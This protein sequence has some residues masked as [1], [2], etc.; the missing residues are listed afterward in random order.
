[1]QLPNYQS[2]VRSTIH[3]K[4]GEVTL[5]EYDKLFQGLEQESNE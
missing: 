4:E 1:M 2:K 3:P 5:F